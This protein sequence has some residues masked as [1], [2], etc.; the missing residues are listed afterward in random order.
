MITQPN[1]WLLDTNVW[2]FGLRRDISFQACAELLDRIGKFSVLIPL[3]VLKELNLVLTE[4]ETQDLYRLVN[5]YSDFIELSWEPVMVDHVR[6]YERR[7]CK[8]GDAVIAAHAEGFGITTIVSENR[9]FLQALN[10]LPV[11]VITPAEAGRRLAPIS[12]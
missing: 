7:G 8:K 6:S 11:E 5:Q 12:S 9:Q 4:S 1:R 10:D 3:Q 2:V